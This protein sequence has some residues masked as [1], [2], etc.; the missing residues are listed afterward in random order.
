MYKVFERFTNPF[1]SQEAGQPPQGLLAFCRFYTQGM[2]LPL[3]AMSLMA[4]VLAIL[5][6]TLFGFM[7]DLVDWLSAYTPETLFVEKRDEL[8]GR[9]EDL[10][11]FFLALFRLR[12]RLL[13]HLFG[14]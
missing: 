3:L 4:A 14:G 5:E 1:P 12:L 8:V 13:L 2:E 7:G 11:L 10:F 6:V 9:F